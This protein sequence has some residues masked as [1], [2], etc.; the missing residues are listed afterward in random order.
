MNSSL[1]DA[2][3]MRV[4]PSDELAPENRGKASI[5]IAAMGKY[6]LE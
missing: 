5:Y 1:T 3:I 6:N 2:A 4:A